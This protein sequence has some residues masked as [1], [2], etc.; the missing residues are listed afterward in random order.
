MTAVHPTTLGP[1]HIAE[2]LGEGAMGVVYKAVD[3]RIDRVVAL[4]TLRLPLHVGTGDGGQRLR[5]RFRQEAV[6]A[7]RLS[8]PGI[9]Q[10]YEFDEHDGVAF[11][12]MEFVEGPTLAQRMERGGR[13]DDAEIDELMLQLLDALQHAHEQRVWHRDIKPAN[14]I[15]TR[16]GRLKV[17]DFGIARVDGGG[18][19]QAGKLVGTPIYIAP[20]QFTGGA[21]DH[22]VDLYAA[23]VVMYQLLA[24]QSPF[25][26]TTQELIYQAVHQ[27]PPL[28]GRLPGVRRAPHY[29]DI[30][31]RALAKDPA[32]RWASARQFAD[33]LR[34]RG[35]QQETT[36]LDV[37]GDA[38][39][40]PAL[41]DDRL[42]A[43]ASTFIGRQT[44]VADALQRLGHER[45]VTLVGPGGTGKTRLALQ[46]AR[47]MQ[48]G[49]ADGARWV[50]LSDLPP[51]APIDSRLAQAL[52]LVEP[53]Q[54]DAT[55]AF[56]KSLAAREQLI[57]LD[58]CEQVL[59]P[60]AGFVD[61]LLA[62]APRMRVLATSRQALGATDESPLPVP[63]MWVESAS[64]TRERRVGCD[65]V[66]LFAARAQA[67]RPSFRLDGEALDAVLQICRRLD[68]MPLAIEL[69]AARIKVLTPAQIAAR[70]DDA[71]RLLG[72]G[73]G[74]RLPRQQTLRAL[75]DWSHDL[76]AP[77]E[78]LAFAR[79]SVFRGDFDLEAAEAVLPDDQLPADEVLDAL[80][81]LADRSL[82]VA[83]EQGEV[84]RYRLLQT[85]HLY[86]RERLGDGPARQAPQRRHA[87]H[88]LQ[89]AQAAAAGLG[90][91]AQAQ[92]LAAFDADAAQCE[93]ALDGSMD[94]GDVDTAV[95]L[96]AAM[97]GVWL[98]KGVVRQGM[99][100]LERLLAETLPDSPV[101]AQLL[102]RASRIAIVVLHRRAQA[103]EWCERGLALA[104]RLGDA[105]VESWFL[106][107]LG[108][109]AFHARDYA[110]AQ[111]WFGRAVDA[112]RRGGDRL[113]EA[114]ALDNLGAVELQSGRLDAACTLIEQALAG[115]RAVG[116]VVELAKCLHNLA[117]AEFNRGQGERAEGLLLESLA[118]QQAVG[119]VRSE[120]MARAQLGINRS[121]RGDPAG[122][123]EALLG[124]AACARRLDDERLLA[125][126]QEHLAGALEGLGR[127]A[128]A[129]AAVRESL[130]LRRRSDNPE[131]LAESLH[132]FAEVLAAR[133]PVLAAR[134]LGHAAALLQRHGV[135]MSANEVAD[136]EQIERAVRAGLDE[137]VYAQERDHG[138]AHDIE[139]LLAL[140]N[141]APQR[142]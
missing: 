30:V 22:R 73:S 83:V 119:D 33:A 11:I 31:S 110:S 1:Y 85:V 15:V 63:A 42:P 10:L 138:A 62:A 141:A 28:P 108:G 13:L 67:L 112:A 104:Q 122:A 107:G 114:M 64:A 39:L 57:V 61:A 142:Q 130:A 38:A 120:T 126:V 80:G 95:P 70:L 19:T 65:A 44:L 125:S 36:L 102:L 20:E 27:L 94:V 71:F 5:A 129:L 21:I 131:D 24:G 106:R 103:R 66:Q 17:A 101:L 72:S 111:A 50:D 4:K 127:H 109:V 43:D 124:A 87:R 89:R 123:R 128:E 137:A 18:V 34:R 41:D 118:I 121:K 139:V 135:S 76:L 23:G 99:P 3:P 117:V 49:L 100:R 54:G 2:V 56:V 97:A 37:A 58:N 35:A 47:L 91:R 46:V 75:F 84:M 8:H 6:A 14:L 113:A 29:D 40:A 74:E 136:V 81:E 105:G 79:L 82:L 59:A 52:D 48:P 9:V 69:A 78:R 96:A 98:A 132:T 55:A 32:Q 7:G 133:Q 77:R 26:G 25:K 16:D 12:A 51:G 86:A 116:S 88:Y 60:V 90:T 92:S 53:P 68:G 93:Q 45:L 134:L 140:A 115:Y